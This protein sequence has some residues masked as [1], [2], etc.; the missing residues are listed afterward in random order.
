MSKYYTAKELRDRINANDNRCTAEPYLLLLRSIRWTV[1]N[2]EYCNGDTLWVEHYTGDHR[3]FDSEQA[4][5]E[6]FK[7]DIGDYSHFDDMD[8]DHIDEEILEF[9]QIKS[10]VKFEYADTEN[11]F[12]TDQGYKDHVSINGH[13]LG[14]HDTYGIHAFRN[15]EMASLLNLIDENIELQ[16][17]L[18]KAEDLI[19][20]FKDYG[21]RHD[22][23]PT[24]QFMPCGCFNSFGNDHW[25]GYIRSQDRSV[26]DRAKDYFKE[27][28]EKSG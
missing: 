6:Y 25:Q 17:K 14:K 8:A 12:L 2:E 15:K 16:N 18:K 10:F 1:G 20:D 11:V 26:R 19:T 28:E 27:N 13:N 7:A 9:F 23:N 22:I 3:E 5:I 24:G 21:T 4:A